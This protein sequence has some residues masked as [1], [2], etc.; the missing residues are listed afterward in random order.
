MNTFINGLCDHYVHNLY[1]QY[2]F[3][4]TYELHIYRVRRLPEKSSRHA[5][6]VPRHASLRRTS[7]QHLPEL[8]SLGF[9]VDIFRFAPSC[10]Y[11]VFCIVRYCIGH[12]I[13]MSSFVYD[14][15]IRFLMI[16]VACLYSMAD[17]VL[18]CTWI[19]IQVLWCVCIF[20]CDSI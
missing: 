6:A 7:R 20:L 1:T 16:F 12:D 13:F 3:T 19:D 9:W 14:Y 5:R 11:A 10:V 8:N 18:V 4:Q 2:S 15:Y 17:R